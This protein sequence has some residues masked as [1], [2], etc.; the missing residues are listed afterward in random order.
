M[1]HKSLWLEYGPVIWF[2]CF[3]VFWY[4]NCWLKVER[5]FFKS[6]CKTKAICILKQNTRDGEMDRNLHD[7]DEF[8]EQGYISLLKR[9]KSSDLTLCRINNFFLQKY[10]EKVFQQCIVRGVN[11]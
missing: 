4:Q 11:I 10:H 9:Y 1:S 6:I 8:L 2:Y 5:T 7:D 3:R